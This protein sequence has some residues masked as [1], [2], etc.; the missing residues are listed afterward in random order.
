MAI[1]VWKKSVLVRSE[2]TIIL[3]SIQEFVQ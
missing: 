1:R 3:R 2:V